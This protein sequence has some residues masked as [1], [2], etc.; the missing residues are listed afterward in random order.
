MLRRSGRMQIRCWWRPFPNEVLAASLDRISLLLAYFAN[1]SARFCCTRCW[2]ETRPEL[3]SFLS[4]EI[5]EQK[6]EN[7][8]NCFQEKLIYSFTTLR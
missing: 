4:P 5:V 1:S 6:V 7:F 8:I 3:A 2:A